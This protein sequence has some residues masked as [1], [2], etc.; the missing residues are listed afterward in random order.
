MIISS[1]KLHKIPKIR[2]GL[3]PPFLVLVWKKL[4]QIY[5]DN[6]TMALL[7]IHIKQKNK[8]QIMRLL[9]NVTIH[10]TLLCMVK[11]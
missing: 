2:V 5:V 4:F 7:V 1:A 3:S 10:I 11:Y 9:W 6:E 8:N